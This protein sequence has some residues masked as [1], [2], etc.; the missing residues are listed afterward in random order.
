M[1]PCFFDFHRQIRMTTKRH[2]NWSF[3]L[4]GLLDYWIGD[5]QSAE[6]LRQAVA[7]DPDDFWQ[8]LSEHRLRNLAFRLVLDDAGNEDWPPRLKRRLLRHREKQV[9]NQAM[10]RKTLE[11][12]EC[13]LQA[14]DI[15]YLVLKGMPLAERL[16]GRALD[17]YQ[18]D[19]DI[20]VRESDLAR[21]CETLTQ[22]GFRLP[23]NAARPSEHQWRTDHAV[24]LA[25]DAVEIDLHWKLR[26]VPAY[27]FDME[28]I[29]ET[30]PTCS[31]PRVAGDEATLLLL[32][33]SVA[34]D[35][36]RP[37]RPLRLKHVVDAL[38]LM[39]SLQDFSWDQ[40]LDDR[41]ADNTLPVI[42]NVLHL[43]KH[44]WPSCFEEPTLLTAMRKRAQLFV[45]LD[46]Q[47]VGRLCV[48]SDSKLDGLFWFLRCY[49]LSYR[50]VVW[51]LD[52][53]FPHFG[54][55]PVNLFRSARFLWRTIAWSLARSTEQLDFTSSRYGRSTDQ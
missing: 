54:R 30:A 2:Q 47:S 52:R 26:N 10:L 42:V 50:D 55:L 33:L 44:L 36:A 20:L 17:R 16:Y 25:R 18:N 7:A 40:F 29:W 28:R 37:R 6:L 46:A 48:S 23:R 35:I 21:A 8:F 12:V 32:L 39:R 4:H 9:T 22:R 43:L 1:V 34:H 27:D 3:Y 31:A 13:E 51:Y 49:P 41:A 14:A 53:Q 15:E 38:V 5:L 24:A 45:P 19:L 11:E